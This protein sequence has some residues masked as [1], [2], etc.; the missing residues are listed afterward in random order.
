MEVPLGWMSVP[1]GYALHRNAPGHAAVGLFES[2]GKPAV[3]VYLPSATG[4]PRLAIPEVPHRWEETRTILGRVFHITEGERG[5]LVAW[6]T[7]PAGSAARGVGPV[8]TT[9]EA[10]PRAAVVL[11]LTRL[12]FDKLEDRDCYARHWRVKENADRVRRWIRIVSN[13]AS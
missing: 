11:I 5:G 1:L 2:A 12:S 6:V 3:K 8:F 7:S 13:S 10:S 4:A 9:D